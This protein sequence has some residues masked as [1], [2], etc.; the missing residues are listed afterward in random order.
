MKGGAG[1]LL[2]G[3]RLAAG[4]EVSGM[5]CVLRTPILPSMGCVLRATILP[6][7]R[8]DFV[9]GNLILSVRYL[10]QRH[11]TSSAP[12]GERHGLSVTYH[13]PTELV[14]CFCPGL[15]SSLCMH[16]DF[17]SGKLILSVRPNAV[18]HCADQ[19]GLGPSAAHAGNLEWRVCNQGGGRE[20]ST[21]IKRRS[22]RLAS[23]NHRRQEQ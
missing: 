3:A 9:R 10:A 16:L 5:A 23:N 20:G 21:N 12:R 14:C 1:R 2:R 8:C 11:T 18:S 22:L 17:V 7:L 15:P 19:R 6:S 4:R 13:H